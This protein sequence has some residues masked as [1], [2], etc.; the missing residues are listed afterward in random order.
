M[1]IEAKSD[2]LVSPARIGRVTYSKSGQS[3]HY[4]GKTFQGCH[5]RKEELALLVRPK[6]FANRRCGLRLSDG[7]HF[8]NALVPE[9]TEDLAHQ[10]GTGALDSECPAG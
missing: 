9:E 4:N 3:V 8:R 5:R 6:M 1:Y 10:T 7:P 2:G